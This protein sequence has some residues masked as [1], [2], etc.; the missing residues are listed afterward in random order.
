[1]KQLI[2]S[3]RNTNSSGAPEGLLVAREK[4][5]PWM[6]LLPLSSLFQKQLDLLMTER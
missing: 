6:L 4:G 1:M 2:A 3:G 5:E